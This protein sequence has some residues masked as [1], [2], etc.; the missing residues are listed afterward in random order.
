LIRYPE[1]SI[2]YL[3]GEF[4]VAGYGL[5]VG[6]GRITHGIPVSPLPRDLRFAP[7]GILYLEASNT[8][9]SVSSVKFQVSNIMNTI[10]ENKQ[11]IVAY[12]RTIADVVATE[13]IERPKLSIWMI[14][15]PFIFVFFFSRMK[16]VVA[17][18]KDFADNFMITRG[19]ALDEACSKVGSGGQPDLEKLCKMSTV[20]EATYPEYCA[21]LELLVDHYRDLLH[22]AGDSYE[23]L[24]RTVYKNR[25]NYLLFLHQLDAVEQRF[26]HALKPH[27]QEVSP[28]VDEIVKTMETGCEKL[29][30]S[31][32]DY[33]FAP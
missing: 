2:Q 13:V 16:K 4:R 10:D 24:I 26:N 1:S 11:L 31:H 22:A 25:S 23:D 17:G 20:P 5:R 29:R 8:K 32:A 9:F 18:R 27:F 28:D 33:V 3:S 15:I 21:W 14:L 12:E 30:R 6:A 19:R 7:T